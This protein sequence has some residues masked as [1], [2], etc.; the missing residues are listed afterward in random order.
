MTMVSSQRI[1]HT[2]F[3]I[4]TCANEKSTVSTEKFQ[5]NTVNHSSLKDVRSLHATPRIA[6]HNIPTGCSLWPICIAV[7]GAGNQERAT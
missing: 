4:F 1:R 6:A 7:Q 5:F 2:L 3:S